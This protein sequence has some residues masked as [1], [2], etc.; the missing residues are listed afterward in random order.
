MEH[1][2]A[3]AARP[4]HFAIED[5][6]GGA[7]ARDGVGDRWKMLRQSIARKQLDVAFPFVGKQSNAIE[8]ALEQPVV[9]AKPFPVSALPPS[10]RAS[11]ASWCQTPY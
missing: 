1:V 2:V 3:A 9:A 5:H 6:F 11:P 4:R 10:V 7:D 8:L